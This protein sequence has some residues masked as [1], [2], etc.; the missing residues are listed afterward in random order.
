MVAS[1][2]I[3]IANRFIQQMVAILSFMTCSKI[4]KSGQFVHLG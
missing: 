3:H 1:T 4:A 2:R